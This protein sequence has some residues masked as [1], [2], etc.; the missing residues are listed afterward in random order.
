[1]VTIYESVRERLLRLGATHPLLRFAFRLQASLYGFKVSVSNGQIA[2]SKGSR[3]LLL[4]VSHY[5]EVPNA[6]HI[7]DLLFATVKPVLKDAKEILD[8][9]KPGLH[10]YQ[11]SDVCLWAPGLVEED[12]MD[13]YTASYFPKP[14]DVVWDAG[15]RRCNFL[16]LCADGRS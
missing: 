6:V 14:G 12:S 9:S 7:W 13:A 11:K 4:P 8:F 2:L 15:A 5:A 1:M 3:Q 10:R 16:F